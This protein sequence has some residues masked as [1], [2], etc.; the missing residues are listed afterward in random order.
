MIHVDEKYMR[1]LTC[2]FNLVDSEEYYKMPEDCRW[3]LELEIFHE[4]NKIF[5]FN[6]RNFERESRRVGKNILVG[7][8]VS[9]S[10]PEA[11]L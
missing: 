9:F 4:E 1:R 5:L 7:S 3:R 8:R 10:S 6:V 2:P 11:R